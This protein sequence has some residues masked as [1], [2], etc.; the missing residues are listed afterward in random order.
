MSTHKDL[1][2]PSGSKG[3]KCVWL[4]K[5]N[6]DR[7][8]CVSHK[9]IAEKIM[10][11]RLFIGTPTLSSKK[12]KRLPSYSNIDFDG[13]LHSWHRKR[14]LLR[15]DAS[16][17]PLGLIPGGASAEVRRVKLRTRMLRNGTYLAQ[18]VQFA[19]AHQL[20]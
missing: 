14:Q 4:G 8:H 3:G 9:F 7:Q 11:G 2:L 19:Q 13:S 16:Q 1:Q 17:T 18:A 5:R 15:C 10:P 20:H 6:S 12:S